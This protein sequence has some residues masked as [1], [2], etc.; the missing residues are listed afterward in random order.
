ME[1][2]QFHISR[3]QKKLMKKAYIMKQKLGNYCNT[4]ITSAFCKK[5]KK[6]HQ[7]KDW[8]ILCLVV[9]TI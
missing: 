9:L 1:R 5:E 2:F 7:K 6:M 8:D 3:F 4:R